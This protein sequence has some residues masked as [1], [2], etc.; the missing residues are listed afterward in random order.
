[1]L[2]AV[3]WSTYF[4]I[5]PTSPF[6][7]SLGS[8]DVFEKQVAYVGKFVKHRPGMR[9]QEFEITH[10]DIDHWAKVVPLMLSDG[11]EIPMPVEHSFSPESKR[12][13]VVGAR[14]GVDA[15]NRYSL[16]LK[17]K[18]ISDDA[19]QQH[20][21]SNVS[22]FVPD[23]YTNA[24][25]GKKYDNPITHLAL[26]NYPVLPGLGPFQALALS[27][28][29]QNPHSGEMKMDLTKIAEAL[30][31]DPAADET[32]I[33]AKIEEL[34]KAAPTDQKPGAPPPA[35]S[36]GAPG[37]STPLPPG[38]E[39]KYKVPAIAASMVSR[40]ATNRSRDIDDL[41]RNGQITTA[42]GTKLKTKWCADGTVRLALSMETGD[43]GFNDI[44]EAL[45]E[46]PKVVQT[47][48][49]KTGLQL[50]NPN[51]GRDASKMGSSR[52]VAKA[53]EMAEKAAKRGGRRTG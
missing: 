5:G 18:F 47:T 19:K 46:N 13:N 24:A 1:M 48:G 43:D 27:M 32:A 28:E 38:A 8:T 12:G 50:S 36:A 10:A 45:K 22:I 2:H 42:V 53:K 21:H 35:A 52:T 20:L 37:G 16:F 11:I 40:E 6:V 4:T 34:K 51:G 25:T 17:T 49:S 23:F 31:L 15:K 26:T 7:L 3:P 30:G 44:I 33:L 29:F 14:V 41:V 39:V 9:P